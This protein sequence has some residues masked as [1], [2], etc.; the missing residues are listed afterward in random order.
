MSN[1]ETV[2]Y[3]FVMELRLFEFVFFV[4]Y[5]FFFIII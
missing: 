5:L 4:V 3:L 1:V 2:G